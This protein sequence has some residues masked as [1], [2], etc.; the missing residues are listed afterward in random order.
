MAYARFSS[1]YRAG[2]PNPTCVLFPT[3]CQYQPD[4]TQNYEVGFKGSALD[5]T[6]SFDASVY[7]IDWKDIQIS[8]FNAISAYFTNASR[9][10]SQGVELSGEARPFKGLTLSAWVAWNDA[11]LKSDLPPDSAVEGRSGDRL[12]YSSR[13][14]GNRKGEFQ[15]TGINRAEFDLPSY[16]QMNLRGG[17]R[18]DSWTFSIFANNVTDRRGALQAFTGLATTPSVLSVNYIQPR[19][20]GAMV[21]RTF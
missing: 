13:F 4:K 21:S 7:Y 18:Y 10:K 1:G 3:P 16:V 11:A 14:S 2:G 9:A 8:V 19:T 12:P 6:L 20:I 5:R 15:A 17:A